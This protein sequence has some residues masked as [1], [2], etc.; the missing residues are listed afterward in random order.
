MF[1]LAQKRK[2]YTTSNHECT[3][4]NITTGMKYSHKYNKLVRTIFG[5]P[6]TSGLAKA[7]FNCSR[8]IGY[9]NLTKLR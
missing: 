1:C 6:S 8:N 9:D 4:T 2:Q 5:C 3:Q 7:A